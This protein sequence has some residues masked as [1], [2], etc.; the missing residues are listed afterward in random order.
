MHG[1]L[2][3]IKQDKGLTTMHAWLEVAAWLRGFD[4]VLSIEHGHEEVNPSTFVVSG[5][6]KTYHKVYLF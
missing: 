2:D 5:R 4:R 3:K 6:C 1:N